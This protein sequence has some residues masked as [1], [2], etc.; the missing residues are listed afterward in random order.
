MIPTLTIKQNNTLSELRRRIQVMEMDKVVVKA[1]ELLY[2]GE[3]IF[4]ATD[5]NTYFIEAGKGEVSEAVR[6]DS[7]LNIRY[8]ENFEILDWINDNPK[9]W[10]LDVE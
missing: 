8:L 7:E 2:P 9:R 10:E 5:G 6:G 3:L 1:T 4:K